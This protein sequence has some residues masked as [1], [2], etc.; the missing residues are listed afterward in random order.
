MSRGLH[1]SIRCT[2]KIC[3]CKYDFYNWY[4]KLWFKIK[5]LLRIN[6]N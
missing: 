5:V 2:D 4:E 6:T 1:Y 3:Y